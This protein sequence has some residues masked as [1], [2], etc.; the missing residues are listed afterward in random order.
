MH[1][2]TALFC[3]F[4]S[5]PGQVENSKTWN[6]ADLWPLSQIPDFS[7]SLAR[8]TMWNCNQHR[9]YNEISVCRHSPDNSWQQRKGKPVRFLNFFSSSFNTSFRLSTRCLLH[10]VKVEW[11]FLKAQPFNSEDKWPGDSSSKDRCRLL[12]IVN[13]KVF[14]MSEKLNFV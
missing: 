9:L 12:V 5:G 1:A 11:Q 10:D 6:R 4:S 14:G 2:P 8:A 7:L 3:R 13:V